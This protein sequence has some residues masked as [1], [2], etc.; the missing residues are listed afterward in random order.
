VGVQDIV[1]RA[2]PAAALDVELSAS[3]F[4]P[5]HAAALGRWADAAQSTGS[6][7]EGEDG[8]S[9][10]IRSSDKEGENS[11]GD[12]EADDEAQHDAPGQADG[13]GEGG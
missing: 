11:S 3:G 4:K 6:G 9:E 1:A 10:E 8:S 13:R 12:E 7:C 5:Q 2:D